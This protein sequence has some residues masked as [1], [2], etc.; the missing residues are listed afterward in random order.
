VDAGTLAQSRSVV[1]FRSDVRP[2]P[3]LRNAP[4]GK[5]MTSESDQESAL[6]SPGEGEGSTPVSQET[7]K[8]GEG[9]ERV[10]V[11]PH[12]V[13]AIEQAIQSVGVR[14][15]DV[16][17][18]D[19]ILA[20]EYHAQGMDLTQAFQQAVIMNAKSDKEKRIAC[21]IASVAPWFDKEHL[22][23][24]I[25]A[26]EKLTHALEEGTRQFYERSNDGGRAAAMMQLDAVIDF[27]EAF[28]SDETGEPIP[29]PVTLPLQRLL[30]AL[31][32]LRF[33][34]R[35]PIIT[36]E[37][38]GGQPRA[39]SSR[40]VTQLQAVTTMQILIEMGLK[41]K[42]LGLDLESAAKAV[43][44]TLRRTGIVF[45]Q[46]AEDWKA[47]EKWREQIQKSVREEPDNVMAKLYHRDLDAWREQIARMRRDGVDL[48]G[49]PVDDREIC[50]RALLHL[51]LFVVQHGDGID[52]DFVKWAGVV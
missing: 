35:G 41:N 25:A 28:M 29:A 22:D 11:E 52:P 51:A 33:G 48:D 5:A 3:P 10:D 2:L 23:A 19:I 43:A 12:H 27:I 46:R 16:S 24:F 30:Y 31:D 15:E 6:P 13:R 36:P 47:I 40:K 38:S 21:A 50:N 34:I 44:E 7:P 32:D 14:P 49:T 8:A 4:A 20:A 45:A 18:D 1:I 9:G 39:S 17:P 26:Y 42:S 37:R